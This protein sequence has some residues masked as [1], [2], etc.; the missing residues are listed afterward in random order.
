IMS[1]LKINQLLLSVILLFFLWPISSGQ[2]DNVDFLRAGATDGIKI[3]EAYVTPWANAF[4]AGLNG[5]WYNTA[6]PHKFGGFD[7]TMAFN[8][9]IVPESA[10]TYNVSDLGLTTLS[11]SGIAST[12]SGPDVTG[13]TLTKKVSDITLT[14]FSLPPGTK[15]RYIPVPTAQAGIG[16]PLGTEVKIR[17]IP[18]INIKDEADIGLWGVGIMHNIMQYIPGNKL[19]PFDISLFGGYTKLEGNVPVN[20]EPDPSVIQ[21]YSAYN[22]STSFNDQKMSATVNALSVSLIGSLNL[23]VITLYGGVGYSKSQTKVALEGNFPT[24]V[25]VTTPSPHA[26]Y[27]DTGVIKGSSID[28]LDIKNFSGLRINAGFRIK[29]A[30]ITIHADYTRS[31]YNVLSA[32]LGISFR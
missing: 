16:L 14:S 18:K 21:N 19:L 1:K 15:W 8:I 6:K 13:P 17:Y 12:V 22:V 24:P 10:G 31:Q 7:I 25:L 23:P 27:N 2:I 32:G 26:E 4:G 30:V 29:L 28:P 20:L 11:G 9:G 3:I 5:S